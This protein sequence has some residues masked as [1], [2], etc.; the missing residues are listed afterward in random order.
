MA[1]GRVHNRNTT[2]G[3]YI[4]DSRLGNQPITDPQSQEAS[5]VNMERDTSQ[6]F[7]PNHPPLRLVVAS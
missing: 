1:T 7:Y 5:R 4:A 3:V 2:K 6:L